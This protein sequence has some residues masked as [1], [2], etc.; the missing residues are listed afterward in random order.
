MFQPDDHA[1]RPSREGWQVAMVEGTTR[2]SKGIW[3]SY[4]AAIKVGRFTVQGELHGQDS[5]IHLLEDKE[6]NVG[7]LE[8]AR[9]L[10]LQS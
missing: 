4:H 7:L 9:C 2:R 10:L 1:V 5:R 8:D 3:A 6:D